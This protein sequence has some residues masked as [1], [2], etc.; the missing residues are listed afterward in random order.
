MSSRIKEEK[1]EKGILIRIKALH[2]PSKQ[3]NLFVWVLAWTFCGIAI[4]SQLFVE[5]QSELRSMILV[6]LAFWLYF[7]F[8]VVKAY[9]WRQKGEERFYI[10]EEEIHYGRIIGERGIM[11]PFKK[12]SI[13]PIRPIDEEKS[14]FV[15]VFSDSYWVI[16]G[17]TLAFTAE[18]KVYPFGL[19]LTEKEKKR[20]SQLI[21]KQ[22]T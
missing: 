1:K 7:E 14:D 10:T 11:R 21:N 5:G 13:N 6:F 17:E 8:K 9:R 15:K 4:G 19:R 18:G 2:D 16:G 3:K 12:E 22:L 20:V